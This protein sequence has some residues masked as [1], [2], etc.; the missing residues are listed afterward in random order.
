MEC[1]P[2]NHPKLCYDLVLLSAQT[3][4]DLSR[5]SPG[6]FQYST[7]KGIIL[8]VFTYMNLSIQFLAGSVSEISSF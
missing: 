3:T 4:T 7:M 5:A 8:C 2:R 6:P 1:S